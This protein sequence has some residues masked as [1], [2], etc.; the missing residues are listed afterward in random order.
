MS[1]FF[2][3]SYVVP[4]VYTQTSFEN[5]LAGAIEALKIPV[6]L[7]EGSE[8]LF[9]TNLAVVRGSS[10]T[11]DQQV[12]QEDETG[13]AVLSVSQTGVVT[14]GAFDGTV[15]KFQVRNY[16][17]VNGDG[18]GTTTT[19]RSAVSVTYDGQPIVVLAVTGST[20]I[21][22]CAQAARVGQIVRC[23]YYFDRTDTQITDTVSDQVTAE[24]AQIWGGVGVATTT[25]GF[26]VTA[27]NNTLS[28]YVDDVNLTVTGS[29]TASS[30]TLTT[31]AKTAQ[32]IANAVNNAAIGS[33]TATVYINNYGQD[34]VLLTADQYIKIGSGSANALLGFVTNQATARNKTFYTFQGPIVDGSNGGIT[35]TDTAD[36]TV[37]VDGVQVIPISV[38]GA[39]RAVTL[40]VAPAASSTVT[41]QYYF[42]SWVDT[43]DYLAN[44]GVTSVTRCGIT[45]DRNDYV[46]GAD[47]ILQ[48]DTIVW[49]TAS[50]VSSGVHTTGK[51]YFGSSQVTTS[52]VD[53]RV[54]ML[55]CTRT[56][57]TIWTLSYQPTVG[58]G[59]DTPIGSASLFQT[60]TNGRIDL[61]S[62]RP[63]TII[64]FWG[65]DVDDAYQRFIDNG[66]LVTGRGLTIVN[67]DSATSSITLAEPIP[68]GGKGFATY[69]PNTLTDNEYTCSCAIPGVSGVGTYTVADQGGAIIYNPT[70]DSGSKGSSL[71]GITI[72]FPSG[73]ANPD[74]LWNSGAQVNEIVTVQF[75]ARP[76]SPA[77]FTAPSAG[78]YYTISSDSDHLRI[79]MNGNAN[80]PIGSALGTSLVDPIGVAAVGVTGFTGSILGEPVTYDADTGGLTWTLDTTNNEVNLNIDGVEVRALA[81]TG[82]SATVGTFVAAINEAVH[83]IT[84]T[85]Q[86]GAVVGTVTLAA[87]ASNIPNYYVGWKLIMTAGPAAGEE[88]EIVTYDSVTKIA[89]V[90]PNFGLAPLGS[91]YYLF[92][93]DTR[94]QYKTKTAFLSPFTVEAAANNRYDT[95]TIGYVGAVTAP[96]SESFII[97]AGTY[98]SAAALAA[99]IQVRLNLGVT[100]NTVA[101]HV[102]PWVYCA[103]DSDGHLVFTFRAATVDGLLGGAFS[104]I[105]QAVGNTDFCLIAGIDADA[106]GT[107]QC[108]I[109]DSGVARRFTIATSPLEH[110]RIVLRNRIVAGGGEYAWSTMARMAAFNAIEQSKIQV[111]AATGNELLELTAGTSVKSSN[112]A[113][114]KP[115]S[116]FGTPGMSGGQYTG[117]VGAARDE[118]QVTFYDGTGAVPD[119]RAFDFTL[120]GVP[121][122]VTFTGSAAGTVTALGSSSAANN[123]AFADAATVTGQIELALSNLPGAPFGAIGVVQAAQIVRREGVGLRLTSVRDDELSRVVIGS[124]AA[125]S[126]LG[127]TAGTTAIRTPVQASEIAAALMS[128]VDTASMANTLFNY[129]SGTNYGAAADHFVAEG[130]AGVALDAL[131]NTYLFIQS[132]TAGS[133]SSLIF[134]TATTGDALRHGTGLGIDALDSAYGESGINGF[135]VRSSNPNGSGSTDTSVL[136]TTLSW[137][138]QD[139]VIGQTYVDEV[140]GLTFTILA[141]PGNIAY[142][143][144]VNATF[145]IN[146]N[147][148]FTTNA[149]APIRAISGV[150]AYVANTYNVGVSDTALVETFERGGSEPTIGDLYYV[151][152]VYTK[153]AFSM[154]LYTKLAAIEAA[155]GT[156][157][158]DNPVSL[159]AYMSIL[160]GAVLVAIKQVPK[161]TDSN[162]GSLTSYRDALDDLETP[163]QGFIAP[164][165]MTL[166]R[167][168]STELYQ[169]LDRHVDI[170]SSVRYKHERTGLIG[171]SAGKTPTDVGNLAQ[172][173]SSTRM[174]IVYPDIVTIP[175]MDALGTT[176]EYLVDG[177]YIAAALAGNRCSPNIDVATPWTGSLLVGFGSLGRILDAVEAN[178]VAV[179]GVTVMEDRPP[180]LRTRHGLTTDP[181]NILTKLPTIIQIADEVQMQSRSVLEQFIGIKYL[182]VVLGQIEGRVAQM[183]RDFVTAQIVAAYTGIKA[184]TA[185]DNPTEADLVA[186]YAPIFPLLYILANFSVRSSL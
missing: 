174:R 157:G 90:T 53:N 180:F 175:L 87:A 123:T 61:P 13:R 128:N 55:E 34:A 81:D 58:N 162:Y 171:V 153:Q 45:P 74:I 141:R 130:V 36:V 140:T 124:G 116:V 64:A 47:F 68:A 48:N 185:A 168:D 118:Y 112:A 26:V 98:A 3:K 165:I 67:V 50:L 94:P 31:G 176:K 166:L 71:T 169:Y 137:L 63:D 109:L 99:H 42:N 158:P 22:E 17:V 85:L 156:V 101:T 43:F 12:V 139:G 92:N 179:Q 114:A 82:A 46:D 172:T 173:L 62:N 73:E 59:R 152:Y 178:Q 52:L 136:K 44:I 57:N 111:D 160:N 100:F 151:S 41:I 117:G 56:S 1:S 148:T 37:K 14:L 113:T 164:N 143:T 106:A 66:G 147:S 167:G 49:G 125:N 77:K 89:T 131:N 119:N 183:F 80:P 144:G 9:Q 170:Q 40:A 104:F 60:V 70:F 29:Q 23:T 19:D 32:Q 184:T 2:T 39:T 108:K 161:A 145:R 96:T 154:A 107:H 72:N 102:A 91:A 65:Y 78:P 126:V 30:I 25:A 122:T 8:T 51:D 21:V 28:V 16:P 11:I 93:L 5:P 27:N 133:S 150:E 181:T 76:A 134:N 15:T 103:A 75:A 97:Q 127:F 88:V 84:G 6:Y 105:E 159:A 4:G 138:A 38:D 129:S 182:P 86:L 163:L 121:V 132:D 155:Y 120:D 186:A 95:I 115:A 135:F 149:N 18:T 79:S 7:G 33:L 177:T 83:G 69:Y 35:T 20:G 146:V 142:P 24:S 10:S 54:F 110:D